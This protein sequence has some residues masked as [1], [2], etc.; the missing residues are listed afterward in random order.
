MAETTGIR[1]LATNL[2]RGAFAAAVLLCSPTALAQEVPP[3]PT[4]DSAPAGS[5]SRQAEVVSV[6]GS[7]FEESVLADSNA[8]GHNTYGMTL[9]DTRLWDSCPPVTEST[10][11][12]HNRGYWYSQVE[13]LM[14]QRLW[15]SENLV[16]AVDS[17]F[18]DG[19][20]P[21]G[22]FRALTLGRSDPGREGSLRMTLGHFLFRDAANRDH[23]F[24]MTYIGGGEFGQSVTLVG[25][26]SLAVPQLQVATQVDFN[27]GFSFNGAARMTV[28]YDSRLNSLEANYTG[29]TRL[30]RDRMEL[31]PDGRWVRRANQG[32]TYQWVAGLRYVD[33]T[34]NIA[35]NAT[36]IVDPLVG[37]DG[38]DG[39][40]L[41]RT[42]NDLFGIQ[43]G[44]GVTFEGEKFS[45]GALGKIGF[46]ANDMKTNNSLTYT[47]DI[48]GVTPTGAGFSDS[49][50]SDTISFMSEFAMVGRYFYRPNISLRA[51]YH[52][53]Y[54]TE[55][56][57]APQQIDFASADARISS[58]G[59][60]FYHGISI[61]VDFYW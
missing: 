45:I 17:G 59:D 6:P 26:E 9:A 49:N 40:Y 56:A 13:A 28:Q 60:A 19:I 20:V 54:V 2:A 57:L 12:W 22:T 47:D 5:G 14:L 1:K 30:E 27:A 34:E 16:L 7:T 42:S 41:G 39:Q 31:Q 38:D 24:E 15:N 8:A 37:F 61:G 48:T 43:G 23:N 10:G 35:W 25:Q 52:A 36:S 44:G 58:N 4:L 55:V 50:R 18:T 32:L 53:F 11:T 51:G 21:I 29:S 3:L 46:L 33:L